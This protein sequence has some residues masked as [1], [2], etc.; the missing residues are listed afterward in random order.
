MLVPPPGNA[1]CAKKAAIRGYIRPQIAARL[2]CNASINRSVLF[3][4]PAV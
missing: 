3:I 1:D 2:S 4:D